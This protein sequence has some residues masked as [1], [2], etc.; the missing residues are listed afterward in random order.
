MKGGAVPTLE[1]S[2]ELE[3]KWVWKVRY[4]LK[5][6]ADEIRQIQMQTGKCNT[7]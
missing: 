2:S 7:S 6:K 1:T 3:V 5:L 4:N